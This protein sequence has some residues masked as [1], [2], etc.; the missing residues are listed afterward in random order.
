MPDS[1]PTYSFCRCPMAPNADSDV[2]HRGL[3][4]YWLFS[5]CKESI[6]RGSLDRRQP[7]SCMPSL[8]SHLLFKLILVTTKCLTKLFTLCLPLI[9]SYFGF[10]LSIFTIGSRPLFSELTGFRLPCT[11]LLLVFKNENFCFCWILVLSDVLVFF[12]FFKNGL[13]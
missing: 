3:L 6:W 10:A 4:R 13:N 1:E 12:W 2:G 7:S 5:H 8:H 11:R 9:T